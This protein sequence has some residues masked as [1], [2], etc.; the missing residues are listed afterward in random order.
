MLRRLVRLSE[1]IFYSLRLFNLCL[2]NLFIYV[3]LG[4]HIRRLNKVVYITESYSPG[5]WLR[6]V[7]SA[8]EC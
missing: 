1:C 8:G 7:F 5:A 4:Y 6:I 3:V 2:L